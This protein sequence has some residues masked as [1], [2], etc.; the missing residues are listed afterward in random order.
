MATGIDFSFSRVPAAVAARNGHAFAVS[1]LTDQNSG[2]RVKQWRADEIAAYRAAGLGVAAV[3]QGGF[4][5]RTVAWRG[6]YD[7]GRA[8]ASKAAVESGRL[9]RPEGAAGRPVYFAVDFDVSEAELG[10]VSAYFDGIASIFDVPNIGVYGGRRV[11]EW[12]MASGKARWFWQSS[13]WSGGRQVP[14]IHLF[15]RLHNVKLEGYDV[16]VNDALNADY[17]Q[18]FDVTPTD[19]WY[20]HAIR[21]ELPEAKTQPTIRPTQFIMHSI[22]APWNEQQLYSYWRDQANEESHFGVDYDGSLGQYM[23]T[24]RRADANYSANRRPDGTGAVSIESA[25]RAQSDDPW[26]DAQIRVLIEVGAWLHHAHGIP[27]RVCRTWDDPGYGYHNLFPQWSIGGA[28]ACPGPLRIRQFSDVVFP[29]IV[30]AAQSGTPFPT[31]DLEEEMKVLGGE[32]R[33]G[34]DPIG[35]LVIP[36][37]VPNGRSMFVNIGADM[38]LVR[39]RVD[40]YVSGQGWRRLGEFTVDQNSDLAF[41]SLPQGTR[42]V[43]IKRLPG[44]G[45]HPD[46]PAAWNVE[47]V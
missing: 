20:P 37:S 8:D 45:I 32:L 39:G 23:P 38:G 43:N 28:T 29:G 5:D 47:I 22:A 15:Q 26:T 19:G 2:H 30:R 17:G 35:N 42:K 9:G 3:W 27:L 18:W 31:P 7:R 16:D 25:S 11:I 40:A 6:G 33:A 34:F 21:L 10:S 24:T 46:T 4:D 13:A 44:D 1:Y 36:P 41:Y 12:A 14:G